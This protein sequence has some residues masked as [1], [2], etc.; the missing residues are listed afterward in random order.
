[1]LANTLLRSIDLNLTEL[2]PPELEG[3]EYGYGILEP[4]PDI[5]IS[6]PVCSLTAANKET[7]WSQ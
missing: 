5:N 1:M 2:S 6:S 7:N 4:L 3:H